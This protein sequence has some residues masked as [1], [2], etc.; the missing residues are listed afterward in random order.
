[1]LVA[2]DEC[3]HRVSTRA[4]ACPGCGAPVQQQSDAADEITLLRVGLSEWWTAVVVT[5]AAARYEAGVLLTGA[6]VDREWIENNMREGGRAVPAGGLSYEDIRDKL[7]RGMLR[8]DDQQRA[9][10]PHCPGCG[11]TSV[12]TDRKGFRAGRAI[13][14]GLLLG[15]VGLLGGAVGSTKTVFVCQRCGRRWNA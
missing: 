2:C 6:T 3:G 14:G 5:A 1:M 13:V 10:G 8:D 15:P 11:S 9:T 7:A 4:T 12:V